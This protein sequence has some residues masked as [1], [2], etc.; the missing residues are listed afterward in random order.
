[1]D[2]NDLKII[3]KK[4]ISD[5]PLD[6]NGKELWNKHLNNLSEEQ[7]QFLYKELRENP[8]F[9]LEITENILEKTEILN[10]GTDE[11]WDNA[12]NGI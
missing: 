9:I 7:L 5:S 4:H 10:L 3:I 2:N 8:K 12:I 11:E 6:A 1:M